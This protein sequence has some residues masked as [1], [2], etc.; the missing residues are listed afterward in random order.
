MVKVTSKEKF[1]RLVAYLR[2]HGYSKGYIRK[3]E[4]EMKSIMES[5]E[6]LKPFIKNETKI[7]RDSDGS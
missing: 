6:T 7:N 5:A 4:T 3:M 2:E 1:A